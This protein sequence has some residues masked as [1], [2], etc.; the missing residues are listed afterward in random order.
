[1]ED[2]IRLL[3]QTPCPGGVIHLRLHAPA[4]AAVA[5]PGQTVQWQQRSWPI[6]RRDAKQGW[7]ELLFQGELPQ[8]LSI[9]GPYDTPLP[10]ASESR[11]WLLMGSLDRLASLI[12][13]ADHLRQHKD[14]QIL[15]LLQA[16]GELPFR[17][18]P[19]QKLLPGIPAGVIAT[20][21]LLNDWGIAVRIA[22]EL[23]RPGCYDGSIEQLASLWLAEQPE[24]VSVLYC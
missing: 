4:I 24:W 9:N 10:L 6:M 5:L 3:S 14:K 19:C 12:S 21:P 8:H 18:V 22:S 15:V 20:L 17:P 16:E 11:S 23:G 13:C 7:I 1:M 2:V